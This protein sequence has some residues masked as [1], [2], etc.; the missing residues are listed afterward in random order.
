M[1]SKVVTQKGNLVN[2]KSTVKPSVSQSQNQ[3]CHVRQRGFNSPTPQDSPQRA[4]RAD[5]NQHIE[6][7]TQGEPSTSNLQAEQARKL[8]DLQHGATKDR[9]YDTEEDSDD[10]PLLNARQDKSMRTSSL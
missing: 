10:I 3:T 6:K 5:A 7:A 9:R 1:V 8:K 2:Q 4:R